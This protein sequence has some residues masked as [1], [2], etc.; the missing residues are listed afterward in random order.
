MKP[1]KEDIQTWIDA[2][3]SGEYKQGRH[4]LQSTE[5]RYWCLGVACKLF[6][7]PQ[8]QDLDENRLVGGLPYDQRNSPEWLT[9]ISTELNKY[10]GHHLNYLNDNMGFTFDEI[11]D[12]L[13]AVYVEE[14]IWK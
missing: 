5:S 2:L 3:R 14:A 13:Q 6:I 10:T 12:V 8:L 11:A 7:E 1:T 9:Y 4:S